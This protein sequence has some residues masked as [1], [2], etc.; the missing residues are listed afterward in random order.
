MG[1]SRRPLN[2]IPKSKAPTGLLGVAKTVCKASLFF[3][4]T[5]VILGIQ[6]TAVFHF[7]AT[8]CESGG[9]PYV[10]VKLEDNFVPPIIF[11]LVFKTNHIMKLSKVQ[12]KSWHVAATITS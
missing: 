11:H 7:V 10:V 3:A 8:L 6:L 1:V 4:K 5:M 9:T 2:L 12:I